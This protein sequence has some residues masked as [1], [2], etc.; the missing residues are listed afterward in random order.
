MS[1][2]EIRDIYS[3]TRLN[4][5]VRAV[6]EDSFPPIWVQ[7]ELSNLARPS[8]GHL[9]FSLKD[10]SS[11]VRC[12]MFKNRNQYLK[13]LPENGMEMVL[14]ANISLYEGRGEFQLIV[15]T[16]EPAGVGALQL[17]FE[18]L[19]NKL[20]KE[21]LFDEQHKI[22]I[23][24]YPGRIGVITSQTGA[25]IRDILNVLK[26][27]FPH[28]GVVVYPVAVQGEESAQ[29]LNSAINTANRRKECD[30]LI[31]SRGGGSL[32]DLW[33]FNDEGVARAIFNSTLPVVSGIGHEIDFTIS[34]FVADK[35]APTPS[36]AAELVSPD[37]SQL[38]ESLSSIRER[39]I[40]YIK[41]LL[42]SYI[43][44][45]NQYEKNLPGPAKQLQNHSQRLDEINLRI[46]RAMSIII[47]INRSNLM[48][49]RAEINQFN[50]ISH[51]NLNKE[52]CHYL[53]RKIYSAITIILNNASNRLDNSR[54][55]LQTISPLSTL[56]RGYAII[57]DENGR[58][59]RDINKVKKGKEIKSE[60]VN[61]SFYSKI[62]RL[63]KK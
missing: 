25:A 22:D 57:T 11:Q 30:V 26:R 52:R 31:I 21:G 1:T 39:L 63:V 12:A 33:S 14:K 6:L 44:L 17:A 35:R 7:G 53:Y 5:E 56:E 16:L 58:I 50:P 27:R 4:R 2:P 48:K 20:Q 60:I 40:K 43:D 49:L 61:G 38:N 37:Q 13:F 62:T 19:K 8:S 51:L 10:K 34:D 54:N 3:V 18:Q 55:T 23:P 42:H 15:D 29:M 9:Y 47:S 24:A 59:I 41:G 45:I 36:A 32:E 28:A 46:Q